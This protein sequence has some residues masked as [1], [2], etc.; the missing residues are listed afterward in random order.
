MLESLQQSP[1]SEKRARI[2]L[3]RTFFWGGYNPSDDNIRER[4]DGV[5][6]RLAPCS[7]AGDSILHA[8]MEGR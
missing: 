1:E 6:M 5:P 7:Q 3:T 4:K 8:C 2:L